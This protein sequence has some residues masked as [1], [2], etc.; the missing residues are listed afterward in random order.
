MN[1]LIMCIDIKCSKAYGMEAKAGRCP[2]A[3][4]PPAIQARTCVDQ[5]G[6][7]A[8]VSNGRKWSC[9]HPISSLGSVITHLRLPGEA[10]R[11]GRPNVEVVSLH[12]HQ[13]CVLS[14]A[15]NYVCTNVQ[16]GTDYSCREGRT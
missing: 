7:A 2:L 16:P 1:E 4:Q 8:V 6:D 3:T 14:H 12:L 11:A 5:P 10:A 9:R 13:A 15:F